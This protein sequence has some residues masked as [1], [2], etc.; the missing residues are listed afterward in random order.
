M[1]L[2]FSHDA[3]LDLFGAYNSTLWPAVVLLWLVSAGVAYRWVYTRNLTRR[4]VFGLLALHWAWSGI[5][6]HWLFFR[7]INP[8]AVLFGA[9]FA[10]QAIIFVWLAITS[11][12]R[13]SVSL[14]L[15]GVLGGIFVFYGLA[16]PLVGFGFGLEYPRIPLFAVPCPTTLVTAGWLLTSADVPRFVSLIPLIWAIVGG[17]AAFML[18]I[19]ADLAL[20]AAAAVLVANILVPRAM[21]AGAAAAVPDR[22]R[23]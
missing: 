13:S 5:V 23:Q 16:Y 2:P 20:V 18:G 8:A 19:R 6:Y 12:G 17:S 21:N 7:R 9:L 14:N 22:A 1:Q 3:F 15:R 10:V 11:R 4:L